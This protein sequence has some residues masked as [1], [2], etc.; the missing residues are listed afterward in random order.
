MTNTLR[1]NLFII[2]AAKSG[3]TSLHHLLSQH[4]GIFLSEPKEPAFFVPELD[5]YP[6]G[7]EWYLSLFEGAGTA[8]YRGESSTHYTKRPLY[9]DVPDR[10]AAFVDEQPR[11]IYLMRD[12]IDRAISNYWHNLRK[13]QEHR[14]MLEAFR[15]V[16][17][18]LAVS[19]YVLQLEPYLERFGRAAVFTSTFEE[20]V[21][22]PESTVADILE[23]LGLEP[24][25]T[26][27]LEKHNAKPGEFTRVRGRGVLH[28]VALSPTWERLSPLAPRW[29]KRAGHKLGYSAG[30]PADADVAEVVRM[31][32]PRMRAR[33]AELEG[34]LG[35]SFDEW[36]T[37]VGESAPERT[38][39]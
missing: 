37:T 13:H 36:T 26:L 38:G 25:P 11:F 8:A 20:L 29:L 9:E 21:T 34:L 2:G 39:G 28:R 4:P 3:T 19:D 14:G 27:E 1:P 15:E 10:I 35:R 30:R 6:R 23:W 16:P 32:Q 12:P 17:E 22:R 7:T 18:Y 31:L 5:Y 24:A 33:V